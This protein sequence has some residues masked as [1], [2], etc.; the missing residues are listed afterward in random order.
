MHDPLALAVVID[1]S[2]CAFEKMHIDIDGFAAGNRYWLVRNPR[3]PETRVA[4]DVSAV[5][6]QKFLSDRL[7]SPVVGQRQNCEPLKAV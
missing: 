5:R 7:A 6:F 2:L 4:V 1:R 3:F